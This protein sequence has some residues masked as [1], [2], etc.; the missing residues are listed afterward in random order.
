MTKTSKQDVFERACVDGDLLTAARFLND[1]DFKLSKTTL[2][3]VLKKAVL[4][5]NIELVKMLL[6]DDRVDP[7]YDDNILLTI[8]AN[9]G[10]I[11]IIKLLLADDRV[12]PA[13]HASKITWMATMNGKID[14]LKLLMS[15]DRVKCK[16]TADELAEYRKLIEENS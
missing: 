16:L 7:S 14:A 9:Y 2:K 10:H 13:K 8:A 4:D 5:N 3:Y 12:D 11:E 1:H 15:D 6:T